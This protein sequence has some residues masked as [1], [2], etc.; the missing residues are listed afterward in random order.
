MLLLL[1]L[2]LFVVGPETPSDFQTSSDV[3]MSVMHPAPPGNEAFLEYEAPPELP[4]VIEEP[5]IVVLK[6]KRQLQL[7]SGS[8]V[9][10]TY[11]VALGLDPVRPKVRLGD[12]ATPEGRY[13]ICRKNPQ[14]KYDVSLGLSY[15][16]P[17]DAERGL[18]EGLI[19]AEEASRI[20]SASESRETPPWNTALGGGI[21]IHGHGSGWDWTEGC[22]ALNAMD[23]E[24]LFRV[25]PIGTSVEIRP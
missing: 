13:Y 9:L 15:P 20:L 21:F 7:L 17:W 6:S 2:S 18:T 1:T 3:R 10:R 23:I 5:S 19:T 24:E 8:S 12:Y 4:P 16:G 22:I 11:A 14:S 25:V